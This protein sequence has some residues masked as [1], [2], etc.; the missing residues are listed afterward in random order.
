MLKY[1]KNSLS[2]K[3]GKPFHSLLEMSVPI[4]RQLLLN[5]SAPKRKVFS[6]LAEAKPKR[7]QNAERREQRGSEYRKGAAMRAWRERKKAQMAFSGGLLQTLSQMCTRRIA[8]AMG[9]S[10]PGSELSSTL[11]PCTLSIRKEP[12]QV[13]H[14]ILQ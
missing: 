9:T 5:L 1:G 2:R 8:A 6:E 11:P 13:H 14:F 3:N 4:T 10:E 12:R 7:L